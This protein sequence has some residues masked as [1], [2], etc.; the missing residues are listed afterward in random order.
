MAEGVFALFS[1]VLQNSN[2]RRA[3][4]AQRGIAARNKRQTDLENVEKK[5]R[6]DAKNKRDLSRAN[7]LAAASGAGGASL[8]SFLSELEQETTLQASFAENIAATSSANQ[9]ASDV[10]QAQA[11]QN[12]GTAALV[13]GLGGAAGA[14]EDFF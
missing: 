4:S 13:Q 14:A 10:S 3:A 2:A 1:A 5:R 6:R 7:A 9:F 11:T 12:Q 8:D